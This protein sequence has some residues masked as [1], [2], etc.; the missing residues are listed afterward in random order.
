MGAAAS[1]G[2]GAVTDALVSLGIFYV[3]T[4]ESIEA[5]ATELDNLIASG[6]V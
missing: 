5:Q 3:P 6:G 4:R 2:R 1:S